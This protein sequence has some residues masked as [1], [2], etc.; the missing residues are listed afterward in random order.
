MKIRKKSVGLIVEG[1]RK[2]VLYCTVLYQGSRSKPQRNLGTYY[3]P[4]SLRA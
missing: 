4:E 2:I 3:L 1:S